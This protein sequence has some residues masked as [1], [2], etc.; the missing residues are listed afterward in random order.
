MLQGCVVLWTR[1]L[2]KVLFVIVVDNR[3]PLPGD[4]EVVVAGSGAPFM[5]N[6]S[7]SGLRVW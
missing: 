6:V 1:T 2:M 4:W 5:G 7:F 3:Y